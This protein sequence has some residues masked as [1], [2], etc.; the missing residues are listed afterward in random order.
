MDRNNGYNPADESGADV[1]TREGGVDRNVSFLIR[2]IASLV[3]TREGGVDRNGFIP[4][5]QKLHSESPPARV[6]WIET[7]WH[8][9]HG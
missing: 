2:L 8:H 3:A 9:E 4:L 5:R 1:A 7:K 6:A